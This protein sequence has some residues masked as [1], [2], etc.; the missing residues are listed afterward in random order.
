MNAQ[1][2]VT[3][4]ARLLLAA[5]FLLAGMSKFGNLA[6]TAGYMASGG[7]PMTTILAPLVAAFE[8]LAALALIIG[9]KARWAA[10]ALA[11]FTVAASFGFHAFWSV[12]PEQAFTQQL[13]FLKN[14][15][16]AGGLLML[17]AFGPGRWSLDER[18]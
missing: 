6:G 11:L 8:V 7:L 14:M 10:L 17:F 13:M 3:L 9:I 4:I 18:A 2:P 12:A 1:A 16:A 5:M 15:A